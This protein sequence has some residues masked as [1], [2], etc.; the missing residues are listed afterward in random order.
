MAVLRD[1]EM[2]G[3]REETRVAK[4]AER[5]EQDGDDKARGGIACMDDAWM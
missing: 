4:Q 2:N 5:A 1:A 3:D